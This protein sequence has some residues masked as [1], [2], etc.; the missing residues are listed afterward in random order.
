MPPFCEAWLQDIQTGL[1]MAADSSTAPEQRI[2]FVDC[3]VEA[4]KQLLSE[5][6]RLTGHSMQVAVPVT[7]LEALVDEATGFDPALDPRLERSMQAFALFV[8]DNVWFRLSPDLRAERCWVPE[9]T[10]ELA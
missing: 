5:F 6:S 2:S 1:V 10:F 8:R 4:F 9:G 7:A 3:L